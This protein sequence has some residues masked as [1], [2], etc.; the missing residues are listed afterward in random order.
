M[1]H[2]AP[3]AAFGV[4]IQAAAVSYSLIPAQSLYEPPF[5]LFDSNARRLHEGDRRTSR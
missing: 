5:E 2:V 1:L 3:S 4:W